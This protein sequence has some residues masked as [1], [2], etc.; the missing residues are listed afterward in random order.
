[1]KDVNSHCENIVAELSIWKARAYDVVRRTD[2]LY[3]SPGH[4]GG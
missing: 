1:M 4:I 3:I 2:K